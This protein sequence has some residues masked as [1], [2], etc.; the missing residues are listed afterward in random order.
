MNTLVPRP[1]R[2]RLAPFKIITLL[3]FG[4]YDWL[5]VVEGAQYRLQLTPMA[6]DMRVSRQRLREHLEWLAEWNYLEEL[7]L[8]R[9]SALVR[10]ATPPNLSYQY[11]AERQEAIQAIQQ[12]EALRAILVDIPHGEPNDE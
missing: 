4:Q 9:G 1:N 8:E 5:E 6:R 10:L 7:V 3:Y 2:V 11:S 12:R